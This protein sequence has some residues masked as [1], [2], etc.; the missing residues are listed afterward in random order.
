MTDKANPSIRHSGNAYETAVAIAEGGGLT[1]G[2]VVPSGEVAL[3]DED[4]DLDESLLNAFAESSAADSLSVAIDPGEAFVHGAWVARD[5]STNIDL[6]ASTNGQTVFVGWNK[7]ESDG[8]IVGLAGDFAADDRRLP[9]WEFDTDGSGVTAARDQRTVGRVER[10]GNDQPLYLGDDDEFEVSFESANSR[11]VVESGSSGSGVEIRD[12]HLYLNENRLY[13]VSEIFAGNGSMRLISDGSGGSYVGLRDGANDR[14]VLRANENGPLDVRGVN[15]D[16]NSNN[17]QNVRKIQT[18]NYLT[19][20]SSGKGDDA[21][22]V[23]DAANSVPLQR[24]NEGGPIEVL[25]SGLVLDG[26]GT[27]PLDIQTGST[28]IR[29][30]STAPGTPGATI[31]PEGV[32]LGGGGVSGEFS[33]GGPATLSGQNV[34]IRGEISPNYDGKIVLNADANI[35]AHGETVEFADNGQLI[36]YGDGGGTSPAIFKENGEI[37]ARDDNGNVT[38]LT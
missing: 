16:M 4:P 15:L 19:L 25:N 36:W 20:V 35:E 26:A 24:W 14:D 11:F 7:T 9:L 32:S 5:T 8:V 18:D 33:V 27:Y 2:Y 13:G 6:A 22:Q 37:K 1:P 29:I 12:D 3:A 38:T 28:G 31:D 17:I 30:S 21:V 23:R 10:L 34:T